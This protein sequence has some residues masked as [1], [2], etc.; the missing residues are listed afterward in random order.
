MLP[1]RLGYAMAGLALVLLGAERFGGYAAGGAALGLFSI[2][3]GALG[4]LRGWLVDRYGQTRPLLVYV[5]VF[6]GGLLLLLVVDAWAFLAVA[7][8][9]GAMSPP[10]LASS[11]ALW[12]SIVPDDL[13]RTAFAVDSASMQVTQI[14]GPALAGAI[15]A[16]ISPTAAMLV[17]VTLVAVGG[18]A[19][20]ALPA[21]RRWAGSA[22]R[23]HGRR[24]LGSP[25][26]RR[27]LLVAALGGTVLGILVIAL[28]A[29]SRG[30]D[31]PAGQGFLLA[32]VGAGS[33]IGG[34]WAGTR[35][36][37]DPVR[38]ASLAA[39]AMAAAVGS[40]AA[41][42]GGA[43]LVVSLLVAGIAYGPLSVSLLELV[44]RCAPPGTTTTAFAVVV[45][46]EGATVS[47]GALL[48]GA[49]T[50]SGRVSASLL[51]ASGVL[52]AISVVY[53]ASR[54]ALASAPGT[55]SGPPDPSRDRLPPIHPAEPAA[56]LPTPFAP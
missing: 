22:R 48:A 4:P 52:A 53:A 43:A 19:Y 51:V 45:A 50:D 11:R 25:G 29:L 23:G 38:T 1:V 18:A 7:T 39:V 36:S 2:G 37:A 41:A 10:L 20:V 17:V 3:A 9:A 32:V 49:L 6:C 16:A 42:A 28:P 12:R 26:V 55:F 30:F 13:L 14:A 47:V 8:I 44:D 15:A 40:A 46:L 21:S 24:F 5:P 27:L 56:T 33:V 34:T 31:T 54:R 35:R